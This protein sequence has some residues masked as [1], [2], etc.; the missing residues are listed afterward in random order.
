ML[1]IEQPIDGIRIHYCP[2]DENTVALLTAAC[3]RTL[4]LTTEL[5]RLSPPTDCRVYTMRSALGYLL[6]SA[7]WPQKTIIAVLSP[8]VWVMLRRSWHLFPAWTQRYRDRPTIG[9]K[10]RGLFEKTDR[11]VSLMILNQEESIDRRIESTFCH[12]LVHAQ[13]AHLKLPMWLDEGIAM[14]TQDAYLGHPLLRP[15][16]LQLVQDHKPKRPPVSY[17]KLPGQPKGDIAYHYARAYWLTRFL[18]G[19]HPH[20]LREILSRRMRHGSI[21]R[22]VARE[23]GVPRRKQWQEIDGLAV[24]SLTE[25]RPE[26]STEH[27]T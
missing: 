9:I 3:Q 1:R 11:H 12:E 14:L 24:Q 23:L 20:V 10:P 2:G 6:R 18:N 25:S 19:R 7:P 22:L 26:V 8:L 4:W 5:W 15:E 16:S 13:S 17:R 27:R 21:D